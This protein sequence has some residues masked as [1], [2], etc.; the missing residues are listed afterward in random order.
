[1]KNGFTIDGRKE[2]IIDEP[3]TAGGNRKTTHTVEYHVTIIRESDIIAVIEPAKGF[4]NYR[5]WLPEGP[6]PANTRSTGNSVSFRVYL[7][8]KKK[9]G[10]K[11]TD[12]ITSV[13]YYFGESVSHEPGYAMNFPATN[14]DTRADLQ[15]GK[16]TDRAD[17][18]REI[19]EINITGAGPGMPVKVESFDYGGY[20]KLQA[21]VTLGT[22]EV[23]QAMDL[24]S[25]KTYM[26]IPYREDDRSQV[27]DIWKAANKAKDLD[28]DY[29]D[30]KG[31]DGV[32]DEHN[33]DGLSLYEEYRGFIE[34]KKHIRTNPLKKDLM[35]CSKLENDHWP[36]GVN[37]FSS[38]TGIVVHYKF[39]EDEFGQPENR[40]DQFANDRVINFNFSKREL[41]VVN[42]HGLA[43]VIDNSISYAE[44]THYAG[45]S[46]K[47]GTPKDFKYLRVGSG[48][49]PDISGYNVVRADVNDDG[50]FKINP[51]GKGVIYTDEYGVTIA[52]EM[53]HCCNV[54][55]H[56]DRD[57]TRTW[58]QQANGSVKE[59]NYDDNGTLLSQRNIVVINED[60]TPCTNWGA[61]Q[62]GVRV[63]NIGLKNG[64][65][66][67]VEDCIMRYDNTSAYAETEQAATRYFM[68]RGTSTAASHA[69][70]QHNYAEITGIGLCDQA[71]GTGVNKATRSP[72][73]RYGDADQ[74]APRGRTSR[75]NCKKQVCINDKYH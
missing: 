10:Q 51:N 59:L 29:D 73:S 28:D 30:E 15:L 22:G 8:D 45:I 54:W 38:V 61:D 70:G 57:I 4:E 13:K 64:Q 40:N 11:I 49:S 65:C 12:G 58:Q 44:A 33:G 18:S 52:H 19:T 16:L 50:T 1:L 60:G 34:N 39:K 75:G 43:M 5:Q 66:S 71:E 72:R 37:I 48:F 67:G 69:N 27:A 32:G 9:P 41:H 24:N 14:P 21:S 63:I 53:L 31:E 25:K 35:V 2:E 42:Q 74:N 36:N 3:L 7:L 20:G 23:L 62:N 56:G 46:G 17:N 68:P 55:H 47:M 6:D 26:P